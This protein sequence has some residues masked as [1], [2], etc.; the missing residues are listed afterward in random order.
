[1][2]TNHTANFAASMDLMDQMKAARARVD[3]ATSDLKS[4]VRAKALMREAM[5]ALP[6]HLAGPQIQALNDMLRALSV[7]QAVAR[8]AL[9]TEEGRFNELMVDVVTA[10]TVAR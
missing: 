10:A 9:A 4:I 1:M 6:D 2:N 7:T 5:D 8:Q 3:R